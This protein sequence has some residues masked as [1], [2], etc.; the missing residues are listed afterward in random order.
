[1]CWNH[2]KYARVVCSFR[3]YNY[4]VVGVAVFITHAWK[5]KK[6]AAEE[7]WITKKRIFF[8]ALATNIK[9]WSNFFFVFIFCQLMH[10]CIRMT[11]TGYHISR[12]LL[13]INYV[14]TAQKSFKVLFTH[15]M[16]R[17]SPLKTLS[18][19]TT[20]FFIYRIV[21][22]FSK[23]REKSKRKIATHWHHDITFYSLNCVHTHRFR[24]RQPTSA[25]NT[26]EW[27]KNIICDFSTVNTH[28]KRVTR[29]WIM[30]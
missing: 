27:K 8:A 25:C 19:Y 29:T 22:N 7:K 24:S 17:A 6:N 4:L 1:M 16:I 18:S 10:I 28:C 3:V 5:E 30:Y 9:R 11:T 12:R 15:E 26:H 21:S 20:F 14:C 13:Q 23:Y 2:Y